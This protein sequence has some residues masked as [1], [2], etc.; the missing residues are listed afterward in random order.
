M[1][2]AGG[3]MCV[4]AC[5]PS[6]AQSVRWGAETLARLFSDYELTGRVGG[7]QKKTVDTN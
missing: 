7:R 2:L 5:V 4:V 1:S 6:S 3:N